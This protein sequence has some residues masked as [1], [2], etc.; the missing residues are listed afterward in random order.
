MQRIGLAF[1]GSEPIDRY[2]EAAQGAERRG[3][4]SFWIAEDYFY[5]DS[6][7]TAGH[8]AAV[9]DSIDLGLFVNAY[10]RHPALLAMTAAS[11][12]EMSGG[13]VRLAVGAGSP[14]VMERV[15]S[16]EK[17]LGRVKCTVQLLRSLLQ[18]EDYHGSCGPFDLDGVTIGES[19]LLPFMGR[20]STVSEAVPTYVA[21]KGPQMVRMAGDIGDGFVISIGYTPG[22]VRDAVMQ[23]RDGLAIRDRNTDAFDVAGFVFCTNEIDRRAME[24]AAR[25]V[26]NAPTSASLHLEGVSDA[27]VD[28]LRAAADADGIEAAI[29][30]VT[31]ELVESLVVVGDRS[32]CCDRIDDY[33]AA[34]LDLPI[35][36]YLGPESPEFVLDVGHTWAA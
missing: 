10:T 6:V 25:Y 4:E 22:M 11:V 3:F 31:T 17:P 1:T 28:A 33:V 20:F 30:L 36:T 32:A 7:S 16:F 13:R 23:V 27:E 34:G 29:E 9:T 21:G 18:T 2:V 35:L 8:I 14:S 12:D 5:R 19:P 26:V 24:F 15:V